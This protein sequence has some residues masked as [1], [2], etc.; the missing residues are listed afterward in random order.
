MTRRGWA[1]RIKKDGK[2]TNHE[3]DESKELLNK[4]KTKNSIVS[5]NISNNVTDNIADKATNKVTDVV[6]DKITNKVTDN[7][8]ISDNVSDKISDNIN[9]NITDSVTNKVTDVVSDKISDKLDLSSRGIPLTKQQIKIYQSLFEYGQKGFITQKF[10]S[11][12]LDIPLPTVR[13]VFRIL[14]EKGLIQFERYQKDGRKGIVYEINRNSKIDPLSLTLSP[15]LS[16]TMSETNQYSSS[17]S[18]YKKTTTEKIEFIFH[19]NPDMGYWIQ[20]GLTQKQFVEW[21]KVGDC[22]AENL[23]QYLS[24][25]KFEMVDLE[26]EKQKPVENVFNWFFRILQKTGSYPKPNGYK[27]HQ[28]K[29]LELEREAI[30]E[31]E[32][33]AKESEELYRRKIEAQIKKDFFNMMNNPE[34]EMYKKCFSKLTDFHKQRGIKGGQAFEAAMRKVFDAML[35]AG[36]ID[37]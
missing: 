21:M 29:Q 23:L 30:Q 8:V 24:Y 15:T 10:L 1:D 37:P 26:M 28:E 2:R 19:E 7:Y 9:N 3:L 31:K 27:S 5:D 35:E 6:S 12:K 22:S 34:G 18:L 17:S 36:E 25:C 4:L 16:V 20:K 13:H 11:E 33:L 14:R 32:R